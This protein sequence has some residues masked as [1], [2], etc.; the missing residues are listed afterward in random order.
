MAGFFLGGFVGIAVGGLVISVVSAGLGAVFGISMKLLGISVLQ[1]FA[2]GALAFDL[3]AFII[4]PLLGIIMDGIEMLPD[5]DKTKV[6]K[7][8]E[9]PRH[10]YKRNVKRIMAYFKNFLI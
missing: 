9:T 7:P 1:A 2:I 8:G 10:P 6:P 3:F 5:R 4:A